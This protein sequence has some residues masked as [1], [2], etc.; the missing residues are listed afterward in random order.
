MLQVFSRTIP[1]SSKEIE[2]LQ[3]GASI[4]SAC[5]YTR[6]P[7]LGLRLEML[8]L[9]RYLFTALPVSESERSRL[10]N[11]KAM[12]SGALWFSGSTEGPTKFRCQRQ[13][14]LHSSLPA[15]SKYLKT[16]E[17]EP[18]RVSVSSVRAIISKT[19]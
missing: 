14:L 8:F 15:W 19:L 4:F 12:A 13:F 5:C 9:L 17:A 1:V 18:D 7:D 10:I 3:R 6:L 16:M 11:A 2:K